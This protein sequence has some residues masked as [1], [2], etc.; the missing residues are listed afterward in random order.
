MSSIEAVVQIKQRNPTWGC[1][2]IAQQIALA[3]GTPIDKDA[4]NYH[5]DDDDY[6]VR[7]FR[8]LVRHPVLTRCVRGS[9]NP[10]I[11]RI[12]EELSIAKNA[13]ARTPLII[14]V[15]TAILQ[16]MITTLRWLA[17]FIFPTLRDRRDLALENLALR[18]LLGV[19]KREA[20]RSPIPDRAPELPRWPVVAMLTPGA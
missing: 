4:K 3:F 14:Q 16:P 12:V 5:D 20:Y 15:V 1:P 8:I 19:L 10:A 9:R 7:I 18:Q 11:C 2:R 6:P 17:I 13:S